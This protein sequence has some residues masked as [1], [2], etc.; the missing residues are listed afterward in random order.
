MGEVHIPVTGPWLL[1]REHKI[2][3]QIRYTKSFAYLKGERNHTE[4][5]IV[6]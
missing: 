3:V 4:I 2:Q 1:P 6:I 5:D